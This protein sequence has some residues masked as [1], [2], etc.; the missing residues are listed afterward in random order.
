MNNRLRHGKT[1]IG[2]EITYE[3]DWPDRVTAAMARE[4]WPEGPHLRC[5]EDVIGYARAVYRDWIEA[6]ALLCDRLGAVRGR[7]LRRYCVYGLG[8]EYEP[9]LAN[10]SQYGSCRQAAV[11]GFEAVM[12]PGTTASA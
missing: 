12:S 6:L 3:G 10:G 2:S 11:V 1:Q 4:A 9:W 7:S 8:A 5:A